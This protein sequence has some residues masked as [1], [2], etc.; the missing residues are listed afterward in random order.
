MNEQTAINFDTPADASER[1]RLTEDGIKRAVDHANLV[2]PDWSDDAYNFLLGYAERHE[3]LT[4]E[5]VRIAAAGTVS[6]PPRNQAW[7]GPVR[8]AAKAGLLA[9][10]GYAHAKDPKVH[11]SPVMVWRSRIY[12]PVP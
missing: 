4:C 1:L 12:V 11:M 2:Q 10:Q 5:Q 3:T 6:Q 7:G 8:R 9:K